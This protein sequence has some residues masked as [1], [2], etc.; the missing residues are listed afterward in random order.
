MR[1][2]LLQL[3]CAILFCGSL[4]AQDTTGIMSIGIIGTAT[5][6]G[7]DADTNLVQDTAD[8]HLWTL[9]I[10]LV[11]GE[12]KFRANDEWVTA[13][14]GDAFPYGIG[15]TT[16]G[17]NNN[18]QVVAGDY[19]IEFND[20]T[21]I[22]YFENLGSNIGIIGS[23]APFSWDRDVNLLPD[24][25]D[26]NKFNI[27][28]DL[29]QGEVKFRQDDDWAVS[30]GNTDFPSGIGITDNGPNIPIAKAGEY[31]ISFDTATGAYEF[32]EIIGF[33]TVGVIGDATVNGWDSATALT[34]D[35]ANPDMWVGAVNLTDGGLQFIGNDSIRWGADAWPSGTATLDG[36]TIPAVAGEWMVSFN[37]KSG[38]YAFTEIVIYESVGIIGT[39]LPTGFEGDDVDMVRDESDST[40]WSLRID[41][42][43]GEAKFRA[44]DA[45]DVN[46]GGGDFP[47][48]VA[49]MGGPNIPV[50]A[51]DYLITFSSLTGDYN[52]QL[53]VEYDAVSLVGR[54]GP[55]G[56]W[57]EEDDMGARDF[58]LTVADDDPQSWSAE[59]VSFTNFA[60]FDDGGV[61]F[62][63]DTSWTVNWGAEDFP[64]GTGTQDGPNIQCMEGTYNVSFNAATGEYAFIDPATSTKDVLKPSEILVFPNPVQEVLNI[65]LGDLELS[66][67]VQLRVYDLSGKLLISQRENARKQMQLDVSTL[68]VGNYSLQLS[69][70]QIIVGKVFSVIE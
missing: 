49:T 59:N 41:L 26:A 52:F 58:F 19:R 51:G 21:G 60:D 66:G 17:V 53:I 27:T 13:W 62:R 65:D 30:W 50:T 1:Q 9:E 38:D 2:R 61:K 24:T 46:W 33:T 44:D 23:A 68:G 37:T 4:T 15:D 64:S 8:S 25:S 22:Y 56:D 67:L 45:W 3:F 43:D 20:S 57:P 70:S 6:N 35:A 55:F 14:G 36:D 39:V 28:I 47:S 42:L 54:S 63:A 29:A 5:P 48:G 31:E 18:I 12:A 16:Q 69:S 7:W 10:T 32:K 40:K 34:Q 11:D